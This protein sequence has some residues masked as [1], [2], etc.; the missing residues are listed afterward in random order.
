M[1]NFLRT[2]LL[3][4]LIFTLAGL[5][6][7]QAE[8][9]FPHGEGQIGYEAVVLCESLTVRQSPSAS[10][11]VVTTVPYGNFILVTEVKDK[12]AKCVLSDSIDAQGGWVNS[13]YIAIDPAWYRTDAKTTVYAWNDLNAPKVGLLEKDVTLAIL[14]IDDEWIVVSLRGASGWIH[15]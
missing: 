10:S 14:R 12:W 2:L 5:S 9:L 15:R 11:K 13:D 7:V 8:I 4:A 6:A 1:K 3:A